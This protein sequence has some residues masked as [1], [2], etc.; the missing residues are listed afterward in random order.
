M[1]KVFGAPN[2]ASIVNVLRLT[3]ID[4]EGGFGPM[5]QAAIIM[6]PCG[7]EVGKIPALGVLSRGQGTGESVEKV[8]DL[9]SNTSANLLFE[10]L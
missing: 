1:R 6:G 10:D 3:A 4:L 2:I 8:V 9:T 7:L 5:F